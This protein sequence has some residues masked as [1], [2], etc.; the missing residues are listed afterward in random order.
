MKSL[1]ATLLVS[2]VSGQAIACNVFKLADEVALSYAK[3]ERAK[4]YEIAWTGTSRAENGEVLTTISFSYVN[5]LSKR[6]V[7]HVVINEKS[8]SQVDSLASEVDVIPVNQ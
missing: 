7:G 4:T 6:K 1:I 3:P 2:L 5:D 8:C